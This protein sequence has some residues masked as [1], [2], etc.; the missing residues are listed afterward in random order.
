MNPCLT[1]G[2]VDYTHI[3]SWVE[4]CWIKS[5]YKCEGCKSEL[6]IDRMFKSP[7]EAEH[8]KQAILQKAMM[9]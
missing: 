5:I 9:M 8:G 7:E 4:G 1:C 6:S 2:A 3:K